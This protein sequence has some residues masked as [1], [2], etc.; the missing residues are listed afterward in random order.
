RPAQQHGAGKLPGMR[1]HADARVLSRRHQYAPIQN[2]S[3]RLNQL[4]KLH[5]AEP[6]DPFCTYGIALEHFKAGRHD[7]A[8]AWLDTTLSIDARYCDAYF[9]KAKVQLER[10]DDEAARATLMQGMHAAREANDDHARSE[11]SELLA[12]IE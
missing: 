11:L 12:S 7:D 3:E 8:L 10:G 5:E 4:I 6:G 1:R 2:M 9:Q